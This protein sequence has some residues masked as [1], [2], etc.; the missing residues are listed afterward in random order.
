MN[1]EAIETL[2]P[3]TLFAIEEPLTIV[4][5]QPWNQLEPAEIE[6]LSKI[7]SSIK[8]GLNS[9]KIICNPLMPIGQLN[10][11][12]TILFGAKVIPAII[13]YELTEYEGKSII[14]ADG[15]KF[16]DDAKKKSLWVALK[17]L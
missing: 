4:I 3:E 7:L 6:L 16:L 8:Q 13:H 2:Y 5:D 9:V 11:K 15:L 14:Q 1:A 17:K 12:K 10:S